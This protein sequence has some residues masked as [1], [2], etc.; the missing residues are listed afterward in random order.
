M[1]TLGTFVAGQILTAAELNAIGTW[2]TFTPSWTNFTVGNATQ[3]FRYTEINKL[4]IVTG[5]L[6]L[7]STSV[8]GTSP[9]F[10]IPNSRTAIGES[11][12]VA[13]IQDA[14]TANFLGVTA[15]TST[16]IV[17]TVELSNATYGAYTDVSATVP[18]TWTTNDAIF[19]TT[20]FPIS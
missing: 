7:G 12:G 14:G 18:M 8:M 10:T 6:T 5:T 9:R 13:R 3:S 16:V 11:Y 1:A 15:A 4:M 17:V 19:L 20:V 2:T